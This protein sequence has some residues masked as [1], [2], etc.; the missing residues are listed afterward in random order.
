VTQVIK[1]KHSTSLSDQLR[2]RERGGIDPTF[3]A[4]SMGTRF[5][6][7]EPRETNHRVHLC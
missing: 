4:S 1:E 3:V 6:G 7:T 2:E 5:F